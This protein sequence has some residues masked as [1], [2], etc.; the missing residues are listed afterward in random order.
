MTLSWR[1]IDMYPTVFNKVLIFYLTFKFHENSVNA[2]GPPP[3]PL[4]S[5]QAQELR[6]R[7]SG[8]GLILIKLEPTWTWMVSQRLYRRWLHSISR[9]MRQRRKNSLRNS[10]P[11]T[12]PINLDTTKRSWSYIRLLG[13]KT[14]KE[15][16]CIILLQESSILWSIKTNIE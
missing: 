13:L 7:P 2:F 3:P 6:K 10:F 15:D 14:F 8:I 12:F 16:D 9:R 5:P 11:V 1:Y 4:P